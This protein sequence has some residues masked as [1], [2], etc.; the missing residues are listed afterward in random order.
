MKATFFNNF[1]LMQSPSLVPTPLT[2]TSSCSA[3]ERREAQESI[4]SPALQTA[5]DLVTQ[6][7]NLA[8][9]RTHL[10]S[11]HLKEILM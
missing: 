9:G 10:P 5:V 6:L 2:P 8:S 4:K 11:P 3:L 7:T 1:V